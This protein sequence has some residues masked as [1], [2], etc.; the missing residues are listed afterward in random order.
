MDANS[1]T[2]TVDL[3]ESTHRISHTPWLSIFKPPRCVDLGHEKNSSEIICN[4]GI[5][6]EIPLPG[7]Y[8]EQNFLTLT[9]LEAQG[10]L[11]L[12]TLGQIPLRRLQHQMP[13]PR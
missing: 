5:K 11:H 7:Q 1:R 12:L 8:I 9:R 4:S 6:T 13:A 3:L 2:A 10:Q